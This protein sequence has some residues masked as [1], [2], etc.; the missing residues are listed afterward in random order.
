MSQSSHLEKEIQLLR[1]WE[2][3]FVAPVGY[4]YG[5]SYSIPSGFLRTRFYFQKIG[6]G[7]FYF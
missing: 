6:G 2:T 5:Y 3:P 1:S 7:R 4:T